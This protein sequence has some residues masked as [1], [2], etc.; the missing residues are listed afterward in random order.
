[1]R[2]E[3][4]FFLKT[5][6]NMSELKR[7]I[8]FLD[9]LDEE[10]VNKRSRSLATS[11][12]LSSCTDIK[13]IKVGEN[14]S[15]E[16]TE[17]KEDESGN[18]TTE[19]LGFMDLPIEIHVA[20]F[21]LLRPFHF[22]Q[23]LKRVSRGFATIVDSDYLWK[24]ID[25]SYFGS[26]KS[27]FGKCE[28]YFISEKELNKS[29]EGDS[30]RYF[31]YK[32]VTTHKD[33]VFYKLRSMDS[34]IHRLYID[35]N[36]E[37]RDYFDLKNILTW[38]SRRGHLNFFRMA[39]KKLKFKSPKETDLRTKDFMYGPVLKGHSKF[40]EM[41]IN[42]FSASVQFIW[43][44]NGH[45][46]LTL[47]AQH[48]HTEIVRLLI[49]EGTDLN[50]R[51]G[52]DKKTGLMFAAWNGH[53]EIVRLLLSHGAEVHLEDTLGET[54][55]DKAV[56]CGHDKVCELLLEE[57]NVD[58][59][60]INPKNHEYS[61]VRAVE[62]DLI[63]T[64]KILLKYMPSP[65]HSVREDT[66]KK[67]QKLFG[68]AFVKACSLRKFE[69]L[70]TIHAH[71]TLTSRRILES[72]DDLFLHQCLHYRSNKTTIKIFKWLLKQ[73]LNPNITEPATRKTALHLAVIYKRLDFVRVLL[74]NEKII[75]NPN[76]VDT[77]GDTPLHYASRYGLYSI[78]KELLKRN[79]IQ[80]D[81]SNDAGYTP[82]SLAVIS[83]VFPIIRLFH[84]KQN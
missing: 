2:K 60:R 12:L 16:K 76:A 56:E 66:Y 30:S 34:H 69:I 37:F 59:F 68:S 63:D 71:D 6:N 38:A 8:Q 14:S 44:E 24:T 80:V 27:Y 17:K 83:G 22:I 47:A 19:T 42:E 81:I 75:T 11:S 29:E 10:N 64:V 3:F 52:H 23:S 43:H 5:S 84:P 53:L 40:L 51:K 36:E 74:R 15:V 39:F 13:A 55:F 9:S 7:N 73:G 67:Y 31:S 77:D 25:E 26:E 62:C 58:P 79:D 1:M 78:A 50:Y 41:L 70:K 18:E 54:A 61:L 21:S 65:S 45:S 28:S 32:R 46:P 4:F 82:S 33:S 72:S 49:K 57:G 20:I 48:G 35:P